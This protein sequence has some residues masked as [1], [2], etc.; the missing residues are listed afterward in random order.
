MAGIWRGWVGTMFWLKNLFCS[1]SKTNTFSSLDSIAKYFGY[2]ISI[3]CSICQVI[4]YSGALFEFICW[5]HDLWDFFD[6]GAQNMSDTNSG[7]IHFARTSPPQICLKGRFK[8]CFFSH[9]FFQVEVLMFP[10]WL[11]N[12][13]SRKALS[14]AS[15]KFLFRLGS[16]WSRCWRYSWNEEMKRWLHDIHT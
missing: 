5:F 8:W 13:S 9:F 6:A 16:N 3:S 7:G 11:Y 12:S 10:S 4:C 2:T 14:A 1:N 15:L